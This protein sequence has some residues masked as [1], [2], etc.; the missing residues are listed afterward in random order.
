VRPDGVAELYEAARLGYPRDIVEF[1]A[2]TAG[3]GTGRAVL[4]V[5]EVGCGTGQLTER[6]ACFG[7]SLTAIDIGP[8]MIAAAWR[9]LDGPAIS[10]Q[11]ASFEDFAAPEASFDLIASGSRCW[12]PENATTITSVR[13]CSACGSPAAPTAGPGRRRR[14]RPPAR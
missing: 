7:F 14:G 9:R 10:F 11:V 6:L 8:S 1:V 4:E 13:H 12:P 2:S 3:L 5:L